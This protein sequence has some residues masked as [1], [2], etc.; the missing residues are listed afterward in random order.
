MMA[1]ATTDRAET[2]SDEIL[3]GAGWS[4]LEPQVERLVSG[5]RAG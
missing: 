1:G 3:A 5:T 2:A 4:R